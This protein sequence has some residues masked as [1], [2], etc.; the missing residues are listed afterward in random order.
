MIDLHTHLLPGVDDGSATIEQSV[1]VLGRFTADGVA[2]LACTPHLLASRA[3][4][5]PIAEHR[6]RMES[7]R[8]SAPPGIDLR[9]GWEIMLDVPGA[10]L[11][12]PHLA[13]EGSRTVLVEFAR[14]AVPNR[15]AEELFRLRMSGLVPMLAHPERYW[16]C[17][18]EQVSE[19]RR[20]GAVI[21]TDTAILLDRGTM[22]R[23]AQAMLEAGQIDLLASDNHGDSRSLAS[24]VR[25]LGEIGATE[26][27]ELLT[28]ENPRR[29]LAGESTL[30]VPPLQL[31][32]GPLARLRHFLLGR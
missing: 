24:A 29:V 2:V 8:A 26:H 31:S 5:A 11:T 3:G 32:R 20:V 4:S 10:D 16:G 30:P 19:W 23:L 1:A 12:P 13:I 9:L 21:Q 6:E 14:T 22:G 7:L 15:G 28:R 27:A 17:S 25:W 18:V